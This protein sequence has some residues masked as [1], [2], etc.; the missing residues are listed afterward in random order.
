MILGAEHVLVIGI[1]L[2][3]A[4]GE[5]LQTA[6]GMQ[7]EFALSGGWQAKIVMPMNDDPFG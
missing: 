3:I 2:A 7:D 6:A 1:C 5:Q 4:S